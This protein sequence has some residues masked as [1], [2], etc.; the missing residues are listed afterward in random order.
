M[1]KRY[2]AYVLLGIIII[3]VSCGEN[4]RNLFSFQSQKEAYLKK[5]KKIN[6]SLAHMWD[7]VGQHALYSPVFLENSYA[8]IAFPQTVDATAFQME[9]LP[10]EKL[11]ILLH[12]TLSSGSIFSSLHIKDTLG[13]YQ[14]ILKPDTTRS[15]FEYATLQQQ[16]I[17]LLVQPTANY[18]H[19]Y[20]VKIQKGPSL[21]WPVANT[22]YSNIGSFWGVDRDGGNRRHEGID[23]FAP[24]GR[25]VIAVADGTIRRVGL[26]NLGGKV[27]FL[28]VDNMPASVYY[29][30]LDSQ[31][32]QSGDV[33]KKG[34]VIGAVGNTGN[35]IST[36]PHLHFGVYTMG[37]AV[38]PL[39]FIRKQTEVSF[40]EPVNIDNVLATGIHNMAY[41]AAPE[42]KSRKSTSNRADT[43]YVKGFTNNYFRIENNNGQKG[44]APVRNWRK[45]F[46]N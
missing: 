21:G 34:D 37:G 38:N 8:E 25:D 43:F 30:H 31:Y 14:E 29:A 23:I 15:F 33:V 12:D 44:F 46:N 9:L 28:R 18:L 24:R 27:I 22:S 1:N 16:Q 36:P 35:A 11:S 41:Y 6:T 42:T 32:V 40:P 5:L 17:V 4:R 20:S 3:A 2:L 26:N 10:G 7:S 39:L 45:H 19:P 13:N